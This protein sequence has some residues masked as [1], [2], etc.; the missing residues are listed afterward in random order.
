MSVKVIGI[1]EVLWDL[2]PSGPQLGGAAGNFACHAQALGARAQIISRVGTDALGGEVLKRFEA[3]NFPL[4]AIQIDPEFP[5]GTVDVKLDAGGVPQFTIHENVAWDQLFA[6]SIALNEISTADAIYF[7]TLAQRSP[8]SR[9]AVQHL[10]A[11]A[12]KDSLKIFDVNLRQKYYSREVIEQSMNLANML[13]LNDQELLILAEMFEL[14]GTPQLQIQ[15]LVDRFDLNVVA[16]TRGA[17]GSV[18]YS[19]GHW[20]EM[21]PASVQVVD[22]VGAG[23]SFT[24]TLTMG[25]LYKM[26][27]DETHRLA[28]AVAGYV[29]SQPG[30]TPPLPDSFRR[31]F[32]EKNHKALDAP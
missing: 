27:L 31:K 24:A 17:E 6:T 9:A 18:V 8:V 10:L 28:A 3:M 5:T 12:P 15:Q 16:L 19:Q 2:F 22:T 1:G 25:L 30:A 23:D 20:S 4:H 29:C 7:G 14:K 11:V 26:N 32:A 21:A 13:K